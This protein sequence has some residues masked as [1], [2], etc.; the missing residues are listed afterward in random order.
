MR[1]LFTAE[2]SDD[3]ATVDPRESF[4]VFSS[5]AEKARPHGQRR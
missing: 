5:K 1:C 2:P 4:D 3:D